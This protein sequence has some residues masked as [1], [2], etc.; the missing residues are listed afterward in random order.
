M[1]ARGFIRSVVP[2]SAICVLFLC[3]AVQNEKPGT[4]VFIV[5]QER[6]YTNQYAEAIDSFSRTDTTASVKDWWLAAANYEM[7]DFYRNLEE[8]FR[9]YEITVLDTLKDQYP[10][11][12]EVAVLN[13][14]NRLTDPQVDVRARDEAIRTLGGVFGE[15]KTA[16]MTSIYDRIF[17]PER[18]GPGTSGLRQALDELRDS[19]FPVGILG[20]LEAAVRLEE[21]RESAGDELTPE[22][23]GHVE[24]KVPGSFL[25]EAEKSPLSFGCTTYY[26]LKSSYYYHRVLALC[27]PH[28]EDPRFRLLALTAH[29]QLGAGEEC[30]LL[31]A[32]IDSSRIGDDVEPFWPEILHE[33]LNVI[34]VQELVNSGDTASALKI[35]RRMVQHPDFA[36][37]YAVAETGVRP[38]G[39]DFRILDSYW[40][41]A[42]AYLMDGAIDELARSC[43]D[44]YGGYLCPL[45]LSYMFLGCIT[46]RTMPRCAET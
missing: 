17:R 26:R 33:K 13:A 9:L 36:R 16:A 3:C 46:C 23:P 21:S 45:S 31:L 29:H 42:R 15:R 39:E 1:K 8:D 2:F 24:I 32:N 12:K 40:E 44:A 14:L 22:R 11:Q 41:A 30:R 37:S 27:L 35:W 4:D 34:R 18:F 38:I 5:A 20:D 25:P 28:A 43:Q 6:F 7:A 10:Q 19:D